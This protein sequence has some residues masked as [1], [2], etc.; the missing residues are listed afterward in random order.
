MMTSESWPGGIRSLARSLEHV[1]IDEYVHQNEAGNQ[2]RTG[3]IRD[4]EV[5]EDLSECFPVRAACK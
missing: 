3:R 5:D 4:D 1:Y 2:R